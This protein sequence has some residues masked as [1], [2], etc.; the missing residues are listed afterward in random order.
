[1]SPAKRYA[2]KQ[3]KAIKRRRLNARER[4]ERR[5][6]EAQ[7]AIDALHQGLHDL[8]LPNDLVA[9]IEGRLRMQKKLL[10]KIFGLMFPPPLRLCHCL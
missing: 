1:M 2:S 8:G 10:G 5:Q 7:R 3:A 4:H 6:R 9:E